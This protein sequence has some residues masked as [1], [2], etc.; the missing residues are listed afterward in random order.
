MEISTIKRM[1]KRHKE[2]EKERTMGK[3]PN[4][5]YDSITDRRIQVRR[6][7]DVLDGLQELHGEEEEDTRGKL[8]VVGF[9]PDPPGRKQANAY[10]HYYYFIQI[11]TLP[12][13]VKL[14]KQRNTT[15]VG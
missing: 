7:E 11:K 12:Q 13:S 5:I 1:V 6:N 3:E 2:K 4:L 8:C 14:I 10:Y 9:A 15:N